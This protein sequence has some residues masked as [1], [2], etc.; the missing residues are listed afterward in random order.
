MN[1]GHYYL[2]SSEEIKG[3]TLK[4]MDGDEVVKEGGEAYL[5]GKDIAL[6]KDM[7]GEIPRSDL[8]L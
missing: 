2:I 8:F 4:I 7:G 6:V 1:G 5:K 3:A